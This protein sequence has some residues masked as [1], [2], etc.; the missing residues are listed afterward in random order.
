MNQVLS[1]LMN[2]EVEEENIPE[3]P[4]P[5]SALQCHILS[6]GNTSAADMPS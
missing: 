1:T 5:G 4:A 6:T 2:M 3:E